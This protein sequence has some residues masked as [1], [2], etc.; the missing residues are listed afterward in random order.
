MDFSFE[1]LYNFVD[2]S[3][4]TIPVTTD[5]KTSV[6]NTFKRIFGADLDV[7]DE[8]PVGRL[9]EAITLLFVNVLGVNAQNAN[10]CRKIPPRI[11]RGAFGRKTPVMSGFSRSSAQRGG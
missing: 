7:S 5:V 11:C 4:I 1:D 3:G 2:N 9:I 10:C 8:T 6:E